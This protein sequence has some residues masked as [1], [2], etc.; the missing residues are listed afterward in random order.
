MARQATQIA[1]PMRTKRPI[2]FEFGIIVNWNQYYTCV[3]T[4]QMT[5]IRKLVHTVCQRKLNCIWSGSLRTDWCLMISTSN[6]TLFFTPTLHTQTPFQHPFKKEPSPTQVEGDRGQEVG[7]EGAGDGRR[8]G[9]KWD[10]QG[11]GK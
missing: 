2:W 11:G 9:R 7:E 8:G 5:N 1:A 6:P 3:N 10:S 4:A